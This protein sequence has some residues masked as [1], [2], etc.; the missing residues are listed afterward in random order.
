MEILNIILHGEKCPLKDKKKKKMFFKE[1]FLVSMS[2]MFLKMLISKGKF[3]SCSV[4]IL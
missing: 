1:S 2:K 3:Q 4:L